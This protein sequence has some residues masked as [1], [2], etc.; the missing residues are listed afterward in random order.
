M[1]FRAGKAFGAFEKRVPGLLIEET[2][3]S[4][5]PNQEHPCCGL[6]GRR[7]WFS[8]ERVLAS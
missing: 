5:I 7:G 6:S 3:E 2:C 8:S 4:S 1:A